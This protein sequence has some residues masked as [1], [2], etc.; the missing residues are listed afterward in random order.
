MSTAGHRIRNLLTALIA[1]AVLL[2]PAVASAAAAE[3]AV[4]DHQMQMME[5]GHCKSIPSAGHDKPDGHGCCLSIFWG[6]AVAPF[7]PWAEI[8]PPAAPPDSSVRVLHRPYLGEIAT[9]PP[10]QALDFTI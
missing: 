1:L 3:A 7:V 2:A 5:A 6:L 10:R 4:S 9:P 8:A